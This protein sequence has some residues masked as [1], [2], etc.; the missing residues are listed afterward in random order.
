M[1]AM[2]LRWNQ[3]QNRLS[4]SATAAQQPWRIVAAGGRRRPCCGAAAA[5]AAA[6]R[7]PPPFFS[8]TSSSSSSTRGL[9]SIATTAS[10]SA[11]GQQPAAAPAAVDD[12]PEAPHVPVLLQ[13]V[14]QSFS[15]RPVK[16]YVDCTLGAGGHATNM[17]QQHPVSRYEWFDAV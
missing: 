12:E 3:N 11:A 16:V 17:L 9:C 13:E 5:A 6:A 1:R 14:L 10:A 2:I 15:G 7:P 8:S 4:R